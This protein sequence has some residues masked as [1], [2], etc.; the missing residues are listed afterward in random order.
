MSYRLPDLT[1]AAAVKAELLNDIAAASGHTTRTVARRLT[2]HSP[3]TRLKTVFAREWANPRVVGAMRVAFARDRGFA[4][5]IAALCGMTRVGVLRRLNKEPGQRLV[6][7]AFPAMAGA[8]E[9]RPA[10]TGAGDSVAE[11][12]EEPEDIVRSPAEGLATLKVAQVR[13]D[14]ERIAALAALVNVPAARV[15]RRLEKEHGARLVRNVFADEWPHPAP[16]EAE[17]IPDS[18]S[19]IGG[20]WE[21]QS[22]LGQGGFGTAYEVVDVRNPSHPRRV[23]KVASGTIPTDRLKQEM[24]LA[25][26]LHHENVCIYRDIGD[27]PRCGTYLVMDH[28]GTSLDD[29]IA[30]SGAFDVQAA[31][32]VV[33]QAAA[34]IDHAH[35]HDVLHQDI[36][37]GN[38]LVHEHKGRLHVLISDFGISLPGRQTVEHGGRPTVM[39]TAPFGYSPGYASPEQRAVMPVSR[40]SDQYSLA[41][42]FCSMLEGRVFEAPWRPRAFRQLNAGQNRALQRALS[43]DKEQR[44]ESCRAFASALEPE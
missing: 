8:D 30:R 2:E 6:G 4:E 7:N 32:E 37:P 18:P 29:L 38:I 27:D 36:K 39:A 17:S 43:L 25:L 28:G 41:L 13:G 23:L 40:R 34:G 26:R 11:A 14:E 31:L 21:V 15:R 19:L 42:V 10:A 33:R 16:A 3:Q 20:R 24:E 1:V 12:A 35:D 22:R 9:G 5:E 44:F